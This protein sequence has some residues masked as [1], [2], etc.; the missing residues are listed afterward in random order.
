[1]L[2]FIHRL[3]KKKKT[4]YSPSDLLYVIIQLDESG[5]RSEIYLV[6]LWHMDR[7]QVK[8]NKAL[9]LIRCLNPSKITICRMENRYLDLKWVRRCSRCKN[10][11][12]HND[13]WLDITSRLWLMLI[14]KD[15]E[16]KRWEV[17]RESNRE[18]INYKQR[19]KYNNCEEFREWKRKDRL[20]RRD[21]NR[22]HRAIY[23]KEWDKNNKDRIKEV[24]SKYYRSSRWF[25]KRIKS[26][27][28]YLFDDKY[29]KKQSQRWN[30]WKLDNIEY[31]KAYW[32]TRSM[33]N[34]DKIRIYNHNKRIR[35]E[36]LEKSKS[37]WT[38][39]TRNIKY[40]LIIQD[41]KCIECWID[42]ADRYTLDHCKSLH[43]WW[44]H[45]ID[46]IQLMCTSCNCKKHTKSYRVVK[47]EKIYL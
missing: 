26:R 30:M 15:C 22:E 7:Y 10:M 33:K 1:M 12:D 40:M 17:Y 23:S 11:K 27:L 31:R 3:N 32:H 37:D 29:R 21:R 34:K 46:N 18:S 19:N 45:S 5:N 13:Y 8:R 38:I 9:S 16:L 2:Q 25:I 6:V 39:N 47:W 4:T 20:S 14:C 35:R 28:V 43:D 44:L 36:Y 41:H 42:I 24:Q